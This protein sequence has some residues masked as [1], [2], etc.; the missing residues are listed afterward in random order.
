MKKIIVV[1]DM[2]ND[3]I[4]GSLGTKE[5]Q[6]MLPRLKNK[7]QQAA[8]SGSAELIFT[9]DTHGENYLSTQEGKNLPIEHCIKGS[10]G[11]EITPE[12]QDFVRQAKAVVEKPTFGS[13]ALPK[14]LGDAD[15]VELV[16]LCT[17]ICVISNALLIKAAYP[18]IQIS[19]DA[20]CCAGVTPESH[21]N[22]LAAMKMCQIK[23]L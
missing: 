4:N 15:E 11:W 10:H 23:V 12:L 9:M 20:N 17:D 2:Q 16:G 14:L 19:V 18:E 6:E 5:A 8:D 1:V 3:F 13:L 22:A 21:R 7:L